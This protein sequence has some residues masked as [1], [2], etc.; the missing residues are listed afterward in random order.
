MVLAAEDFVQSLS[1]L[2]IKFGMGHKLSAYFYFLFGLNRFEIL[3][4]AWSL[5]GDTLSKVL[6]L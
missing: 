6:N 1:E 2:E 3:V 5:D 4:I